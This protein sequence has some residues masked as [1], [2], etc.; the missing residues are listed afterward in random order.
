MTDYPKVTF[1][2]IVLNGEP[3]TLYNLRAIYPYAHEI[4][5]VEGASPAAETI[6]TKDGH[7]TDSTLDSLYQF[8]EGED[9]ENKLQIITAED[10]GYP[11]GFW[12]GEKH[13]QS[14]AYAKRATGDYLW[15]VDVDE[16]YKPEDMEVVLHLLISNPT[17]TAVSFKMITFWGGLDYI[18]DGWYL[19]R[20][21]DIYHRLF[22]WSPDHHYVTHRP[23]TVHDSNGKDMREIKWIGGEYLAKRGI[24]LYHYSLLFPKQVMDK[25]IYYSQADWAERKEAKKWAEEV[26]MNLEKPFRVHNVYEYPSW[27]SEYNGSHPPQI[28]ALFSDIKSGGVKISRRETED[29][30]KLISKKSYILMQKFLKFIS[31]FDKLGYQFGLPGLNRANRFIKKYLF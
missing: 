8:K 5:V 14:Q 6:A 15:Q 22:K 24:K 18:T 10:E 23:P 7:S 29:I 9:S 1:G 31:F 30:Q 4:I 27:L 21:A 25:C 3:F 20:G 17:I 13:E 12:P 26:F 2:M 16:F 19:H 28:E 11:N